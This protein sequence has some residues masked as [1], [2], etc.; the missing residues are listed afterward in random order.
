M[1][2]HTE[3]HRTIPQVG[4]VH[5]IGLR[6]DVRTPVHVVESVMANVDRGLIG[7]RTDGGDQRKRQVTLIQLEHLE[8]I[9]TILGHSRF[10]G[11][12]AID[13]G[14]LRRNIVVGGINLT[15]LKHQSF[16]IGGAVLHGT[17]ECAP[18]SRMEE[19]LGAGGYCAMRGHGG[20]T[21]RVERSGVIRVGDPVQWQRQPS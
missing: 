7:D 16:Q 9:R 15:A 11:F 13:P 1:T 5:W 18:C 2:D 14:L 21:A 17:G 20:L 4:R 19:N 8:V 6:P 3:L 12:L 10:S